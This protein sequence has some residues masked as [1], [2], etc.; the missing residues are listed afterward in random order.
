MVGEN[1]QKKSNQSKLLLLLSTMVFLTNGDIY[2]GAPLLIDIAG[3]LKIEVGSAALSVTSY[4]FAFGFFTI[5][6]GPLGDRIG[7]TKIPAQH[8]RRN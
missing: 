7:K 3:D 6:L 1:E 4:M 8:K 2:S 5:F